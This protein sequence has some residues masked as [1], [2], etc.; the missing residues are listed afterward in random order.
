[1]RMHF[2]VAGMLIASLS[3]FS[4][5]TEAQVPTVTDVGAATVPTPSVARPVAS[6]PKET[7]LRIEITT[8]RAQLTAGE[9]IG[10]SAEI[11][12]ESADQ[13]IVL[14]ETSVTLTVP[15]E[16]TGANDT[17]TWPAYFPTEHSPDVNSDAFAQLVLQPKSTY[18]VFWTPVDARPRQPE[19]NASVWRR[20][21]IQFHNLAEHLISD[22]GFILF[23]PGDYRLTAQIKYWVGSDANA[24]ATYRTAQKTVIVRVAAPQFVIIIGAVFGGLV[25]YLLLPQSGRERR[26]AT[27]IGPGS[28]FVETILVRVWHRTYPLFGA[29]LLSAIVTILLARISDTPFPVKV[30][31]HDVWGAI[32]IGFV[33]N[34]VGTKLI[35]RF[36]PESE[37]RATLVGQGGTITGA[38]T[39]VSQNHEV[40]NDNEGGQKVSETSPPVSSG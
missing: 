16:M 7:P 30:T 33:A 3:G 1:M 36:F 6:S 28:T 14:K 31:I 15:P 40:V 26:T 8:S 37:R 32:T 29:C 24:I 9:G 4:A 19:L 10:V 5:T 34:Y 17:R 20:A 12:N 38:S 23:T 21:G 25:A 18:Q 11:T 2:V 35:A 27:T 22:L 13:P 39:S